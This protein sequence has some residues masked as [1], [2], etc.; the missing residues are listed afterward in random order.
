VAR[1][2]KLYCHV[3]RAVPIEQYG[4]K[5]HSEHAEE[6]E[7]ADGDDPEAVFAAMRT[8]VVTRV[9]NDLKAFGKTT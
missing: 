6:V 4:G 3:A 8:R 5:F 2:T 7:L 1:V 9:L